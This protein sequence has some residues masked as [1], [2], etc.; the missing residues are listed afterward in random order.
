LC[1]TAKLARQWQIRVL[2][3]ARDVT[4][5][6]AHVRFAPKATVEPSHCNPP[7]RA[8][9][10]CDQSQQGRP[11]FDHLV[12]K[13]EQRLRDFEAERLS[14]LEVDGEFVL[15]RRLYWQVSR[16]LALEDTIDIADGAP[17][18]IDK[19]RAYD[20]KPPRLTKKRSK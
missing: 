15:G 4:V 2:S 13:R 8:I 3:A 18:L 19:I 6:A 10:G 11:L 9:S 14:G 17:V 1:I 7:L 5:A 20:I 16:L 12:G